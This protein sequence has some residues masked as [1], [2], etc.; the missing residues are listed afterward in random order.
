MVTRIAFIGA[1]NMATALMSGILRAGLVG[2][3]EVAASDLAQDRLRT[4][5]GQYGIT[6]FSDNI[7]AIGG[8]ET[9]V[10]A[11][12][13]QQSRTVLAEIAN[14]LTPDQ[15]VIS[16]MAG[17]ALET[18]REALV[19]HQRIVRVMPNLAATVG[20]GV[21]A[22]AFPLDLPS[23]CKEIAIRILNTVGSTLVLEEDLLDAETALASSG[24]GFVY[25]LMESFRTAGAQ[26]GFTVEVADRL[27]RETFKGALKLLDESGEDPAELRR[28]VTSPGGLTQAG[29]EA[30]D[31][32]GLDQVILKGLRAARDRGR[33]LRG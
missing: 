27:T 21:S 28:R 26:L 24:L 5:A 22:L 15:L 12:K 25:R 8:A 30:F 23:S 17:V 2:P 20:L 3:H 11:V 14:R 32:S 18:L 31:K 16:I 13:P 10:L 4:V 6:P 29:L 19:G 1:G 7:M 9:V 33:Q